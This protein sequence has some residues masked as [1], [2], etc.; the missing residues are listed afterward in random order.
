MRAR[1]G[2][3]H[4]QFA[5]THLQ[6]LSCGNLVRGFSAETTHHCWHNNVSGVGE[7]VACRSSPRISC[8]VPVRTHMPQFNG[9]GCASHSEAAAGLTAPE[10]HFP[11]GCRTNMSHKSHE[12]PRLAKRTLGPEAR[13]ASVWGSDAVR[14]VLACNPGI[15]P[16]E[17]DDLRLFKEPPMVAIERDG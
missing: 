9:V 3:L 5:S 6:R 2:R 8:A 10:S 1:F 4:A 14:T 11:Q 12:I 13:R 15:R 16:S 7:I 17:V